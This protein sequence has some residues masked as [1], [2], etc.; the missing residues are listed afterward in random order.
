GARLIEFYLAVFRQRSLRVVDVRRMD[1]A[2]LIDVSRCRIT[3]P[4]MI[5]F[6]A[7]FATFALT[8]SRP[9]LTA[10]QQSGCWILDKVTTL[11]QCHGF[12]T[13]RMSSAGRKCTVPT[14]LTDNPVEPI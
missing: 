1:Y 12:T 3:R 14:V 9:R 13:T 11:L 8:V 10:L 2:V 6:A 7:T 5:A 4:R